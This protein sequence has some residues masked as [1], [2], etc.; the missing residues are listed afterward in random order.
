MKKKK[1]GILR[2]IGTAFWILCVLTSIFGLLTMIE[3]KDLSTFN[4]WII[5]VF[6]SVLGYWL[7]R[8]RKEKDAAEEASIQIANAPFQSILFCRSVCF[9]LNADVNSILVL[10]MTFPSVLFST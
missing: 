5:Y 9:G 4:L 7:I 6:A 1:H 3:R 10:L 2:T 8:R